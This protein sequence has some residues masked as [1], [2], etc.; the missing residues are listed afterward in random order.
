MGVEYSLNQEEILL[1]LQEPAPPETTAPVARMF[2]S[3]TDPRSSSYK[4]ILIRP[5]I[6]WGR[7]IPLGL[8]PL[9][10][11]A[12]CLWGLGKLGCGPGWSRGTAAGVLILWF[13]LRGKAMVLTLVRVYQRYAPEGTRMKCRYEPSCSQYMIG[14]LEKYGLLRGFWKGVG[15]LRRC[16]RTGGGFDQ[17]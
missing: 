11:A 9:A 13:V 6:P 5:P 17:P 15:R 3:T 8:V 14:A 4:R 7:V 10:V 16:N 12:A 1:E 2:G